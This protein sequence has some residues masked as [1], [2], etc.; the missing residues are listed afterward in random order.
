MFLCWPKAY[1]VQFFFKFCDKFL[2]CSVG[3]FVCIQYF[4]LN[5]CNVSR[6]GDIFQLHN[7]YSNVHVNYRARDYSIE[8]RFK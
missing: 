1:D 2:F 3:T 8:C 5:S 6:K 7:L 4:I